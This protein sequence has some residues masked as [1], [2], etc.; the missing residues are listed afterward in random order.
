[1]IAKAAVISHGAN[2]VRYA[3]E[4]DKAEII[5]LNLLP[6][7]IPLESIWQRMVIHQKKF[8]AKLSRH[9]PLQNNAIR[10]EVSPA[11][12]ESEGWTHA[13]WERLAN[14]FVQEFDRINMSSRAGR[15]SAARTNLGDSQYVVALHR[16]S[17]SG[18]AHLH[19]VA[20]RVDM[21]GNVN[22]AHFIYERAMAAARRINVRRGWL[23][24]EERSEQNRQQIADDC[25]DI[26]QQMSCFDWG[27]YVQRLGRK[28]YVV[29]L[30][31]GSKDVVRGYTIGKGN[32][33]Y[34][35]SQLGAG[36]HLT[37]SK[38]EETWKSLHPVEQ[39]AAAEATG[40]SEAQPTQATVPQQT[41]QSADQPAAHVA[42]QPRVKPTPIEH[43]DIEVADKHYRVDLPKTADSVIADTMSLADAEE[44]AAGIVE[45][46]K[47]AVLLFAGYVDAATAMSESHGGGG[48]APSSGWGRDKDEDEHEWGRRCARMAMEMSRPRRR[49]WRR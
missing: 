40:Y 45:M 24:A 10:I 9:R 25:L 17:R 26:L 46:Q 11:R 34:K 15:E 12:N 20:N 6:Y 7:D 23:T 49:G 19:I 13:G 18:I 14:D 35:S 29:N 44:F 41:S 21:E 31:R 43:Y 33:V 39:T 30:K 38:I 47:T 5:K 48:S 3:T 28:G 8:E 42:T 1:M 32:S 2:A 4:K 37:P 16:D 27:E 22:D 36:R